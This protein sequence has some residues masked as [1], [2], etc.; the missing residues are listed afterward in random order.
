M[1]LYERTLPFLLGLPRLVSNGQH[2]D[3]NKTKGHSLPMDA[4]EPKS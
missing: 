4:N 1:F 2:Q 3:N